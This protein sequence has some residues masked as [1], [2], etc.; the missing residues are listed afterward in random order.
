G[1]GAGPV[2]T[3]AP[4]AVAPKEPEAGPVLPPVSYE[5]QGRRDPFI[6]VSIA[7]EGA[8]I[9]VSTVRLVGVVQ[10]R[11]QLLAL[12]EAPDGIGYILKL[13]DTFGDGRVTAITANSVT[14]AVAP[15]GGQ[16]ATT[17]TL[18]LPTD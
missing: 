13:G 9:T 17:L 4:P 1:T 18:R 10:G 3:P 6:A 14:F 12:V 15:R 8:G 11:Q 5:P 7:R 16:K 2:A